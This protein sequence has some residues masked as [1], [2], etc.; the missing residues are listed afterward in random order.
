[1]VEH[2]CLFFG[3][4]YR[5]VLEFDSRNFCVSNHVW[6]V[7]QFEEDR[8]YLRRRLWP[9]KLLI[10]FSL[11]VCIGFVF[12]FWDNGCCCFNLSLINANG[13]FKKIFSIWKLWGLLLWFLKLLKL[14]DSFDF[15]IVELMNFYVVLFYSSPQSFFFSSSFSIY[16]FLRFAELVIT[17]QYVK[18]IWLLS[19]R[20][21]ILHL[22]WNFCSCGITISFGLVYF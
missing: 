11:F 12:K 1:M 13:I 16:L 21:L 15:L 6:W 18:C 20:L 2:L 19:L 10:F 7:L 4:F 3:Q 22:N 17:M 14:A 8:W 9:G 5:V